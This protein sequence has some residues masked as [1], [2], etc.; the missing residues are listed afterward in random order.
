MTTENNPTSNQ[1]SSD[2]RSA[3][4]PLWMGFNLRMQ[5]TV[6]I[7]YTHQDSPSKDSPSELFGEKTQA[8][9]VGQ[10]GRSAVGDPALSQN[11]QTNSELGRGTVQSGDSSD[12]LPLQPNSLIPKYSRTTKYRWGC[13]RMASSNDAFRDSDHIHCS[14]AHHSLLYCPGDSCGG[15]PG[16]KPRHL[17]CLPTGITTSETRE[18]SWSQLRREVKRWSSSPGIHAS[19]ILAGGA[20][21]QRDSIWPRD[22]ALVCHYSRSEATY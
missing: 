9:V 11:A 6:T 7:P 8:R 18:R 22:S 1:I 15:A 5:P 19:R 13:F 12:R 3:G 21:H 14:T 10:Y 20:I 17:G 2:R 16:C 4:P